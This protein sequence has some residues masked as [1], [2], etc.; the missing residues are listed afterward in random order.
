LA[1]SLKIHK[2][3]LLHGKK[4]GL[5]EAEIWWIEAH[6]FGVY[7]ER[8]GQADT[9]ASLVQEEISRNI[10]TRVRESQM[11]RPSLEPNR[12]AIEK[13]PLRSKWLLATITF[14]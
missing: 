4:A 11:Q 7:L 8:Q 10:H 3:N 1:I 2:M 5:E 6:L 9:C 12:V 13:S 14:Y